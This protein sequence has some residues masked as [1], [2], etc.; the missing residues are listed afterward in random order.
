MKR[1]KIK[2]VIAIAWLSVRTLQLG[3]LGHCAYRIEGTVIVGSMRLQ[4][5]LA[6]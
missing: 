3:A 4:T 5:R 1:I 2:D 6:S